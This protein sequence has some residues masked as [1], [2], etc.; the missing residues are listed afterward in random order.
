MN[1]S[2]DGDDSVPEIYD[3]RFE[4]PNGTSAV[5]GLGELET[6]SV[7]ELLLVRTY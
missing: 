7:T 3:E 6:A 4:L 5:R 2:V 1:G